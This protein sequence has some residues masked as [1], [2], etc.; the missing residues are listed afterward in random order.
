MKKQLLLGILTFIISLSAFGVVE[1][2]GTRSTSAEMLSDVGHDDT[3]STSE[4]YLPLVVQ[5]QTGI[6]LSPEEVTGLPATGPAWNNVLNAAQQNTSA[7]NISDK[8]DNTDVYVLAKAL[9]YARSGEARYHDEVVMSIT[10]AMGTEAGPG[11]GILAVAR[12]VQGYVLAADLI[13]LA[14]TNPALDADF[15][16]WLAAIRSSKFG[17]DDDD[18]V[19]SIITC[20]EKRANNIGT[21]CGATRTA[22]A[23]Y[24]G[25]AVE[26]DRVATVFK[27]WLGDRS[28]YAGFNYGDLWWQCDP[29]KPVG[30][31]PAGCT[32]DGHSVDGVLPD[33][34]RRGGAFT[35]PPPQENYAWGGLQGAIVQAQLLHRAGYPAWEWEDKALLRAVT[36]LH[37]QANYPAEGDDAWQPWLINAAYGTAFPAKTPAGP[38]KGMGWTDW[39]A[40][41]QP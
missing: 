3:L 21:H 26:L 17:D 15:R 10:A 40:A 29:A 36:W 35:W 4:I 33:D 41:I 22:I 38:G 9:V 11:T 28:A 27:G 32:I 1:T 8:E 39:T 34:Q 14:A 23:L 5:G 7:P 6:W 24:L 2:T 18:D 16:A 13:N 37:E 20:H 12:N 25:D 30:I 19:L 31:N